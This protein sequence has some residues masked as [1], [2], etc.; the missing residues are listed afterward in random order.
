MRNF[1]IHGEGT[2]TLSRDGTATLDVDSNVEGRQR[3]DA[4]LG[5][6]IE[7]PGGSA[8]LN[9]RSRHS[10]R[11]VRD[12]P[13]NIMIIELRV[14]GR[15]CTLKVESRLKPGRRQYTFATQ[16]GLAYCDRPVITKTTCE[17]F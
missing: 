1:P 3:Y 10:L 13:N 6:R 14:V 16:L 9:V 5:G 11:V 4:K 12:Y 15:A 8:S 7:T 2:G 17:P